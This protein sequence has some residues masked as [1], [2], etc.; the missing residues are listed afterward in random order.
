MVFVARCCPLTAPWRNRIRALTS[1]DTGLVLKTKADSNGIYNFS[2]IKIGNFTVSATAPGFQTTSQQNVHVD[3]QERLN[4]VLVLQPGVVSQTV[5]V[6]SAPPL[7]QTQQGAVGQ[8]LSTRTINDTPLNGRN[9]VYIAQLTAGADPSVGSRGGGSGDFEANGQVAE[10]NDFIMDGVDNNENSADFLNGASFV[11]RPPPDALAEFKV[12]TSN[13]GAEFGHSAGAVI[14]ASIKSGTNQ[15]HGDLWEYFR[16][17]DLDAKDWN[18]LT[19]PTY[20]E[21]QFGATLGLPIVRNKLFF[22]GDA[23]ANRIVY[24]QTSTLSVPT[25]LMRQGNFSELLNPSLTGANKPITLYQPNSGGTALL[26]CNGQQNVFC[27]SQIDP[28]AKTLI[29]LYPQPNTNNG[30]TYNNY[31]TTLNSSSNTWQWDTRMDYNPSAK[32]QMFGR[33]SYLHAPGHIPGPLGPILDGRAYNNGTIINRTE[34][35]AGSETHSF[36][37]NL[38]NEF[39]FGYS[40]GFFGFLQENYQTNIAANIG[41]GGTQFGPQYPD[42]GGLPTFFISGAEG[43]GVGEANGVTTTGSPAYNPILEHQNAYQI[44]DNVTKIAGNHSLKFGIQLMSLRYQTLQPPYSH[45]TYS[46][47]GLYTSNLGASFTGYGVADLL[48]GQNNA[49][50]ISPIIKANDERWYRSG[51][52]QDDW[53]VTPRLTL[54]LGVRYDYLQPYKEMNGQKANFFTTGALGIATG[55]GAYQIPVQ[56]KGVFIAPWFTALLTKDNIALQYINNPR[57]VENQKTN[58][59]PRLGFAYQLDP[60]TV[61]RGGWGMFYGG[62]ENIGFSPNIAN[63]YPFEYT[64]TFPASNCFPNNCVSNGIT[65]ER[66]FSEALAVG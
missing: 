38:I 10:Q 3:V 62:L 30:R 58:F 36:S 23:E 5:T 29:N 39:R 26:Q 17:N 19:I 11:V 41:I 32:D 51:Y 50:N 63:N 49:S 61:I 44:L 31:V 47:S 2:P 42:N 27:A 33:F 40:Y 45:G 57:M 60:A 55:S 56:S 24:G 21:N 15:I 20:H 65:L 16:N 12:E 13:Y 25:P 14:N 48:A 6:S 46:F 9:W 34:N 59:A 8:V 28:V 53:R 66:G 35:F 1:T 37:S 54:N 18:A 52:A 4:V 22:F 43:A 7:L 64:D